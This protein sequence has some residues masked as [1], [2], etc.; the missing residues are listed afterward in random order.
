MHAYKSVQ[1]DYFGSIVLIHKSRIFPLNMA[2]YS[3]LTS[4]WVPAKTAATHLHDA[5]YEVGYT[6][7]QMQKVTVTLNL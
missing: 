7:N 3:M 2:I 4:Y 1:I 5:K 6:S